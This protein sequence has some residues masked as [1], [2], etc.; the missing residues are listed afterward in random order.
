LPDLASRLRS[1]WPIEHGAP[2][3]ELL[4]LELV[5]LIADRQL[6]VDAGVIDTIATRMERSL[7]AASRIVGELD[8][9]SLAG[10][11][12]VTR[13]LAVTTMQRV[14]DGQPDLFGG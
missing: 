9:E 4:R 10:Q 13:Q 3:D 6:A 2:D 1:T 8:R 12:P 11:R 14:V 5:Q 7:E